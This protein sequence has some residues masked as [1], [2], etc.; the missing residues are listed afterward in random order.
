LGVI[1][2][3]DLEKAYDHV[4]WEFL[5]YMLRRCGFGGKWCSWI[6]HCIFSVRFF[7][8]VNGTSIAFFSS[9][10][11]LRQE[12]PL[13]SLLFVIVVEVL[14][15]MI[16][17]TVIGGLLSGFSVGTGTDISI[18]CLLMIPYFYVG[19]TQIIYTFYGVYS[20]YLEQCRV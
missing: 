7:V 1:Y 14:G 13:S 18:F 8:L 11:G 12:D 5:L 19:P 6:A 9:F 17:A 4:S 10:R 15:K 20:Y 2:K 3:L 16:S